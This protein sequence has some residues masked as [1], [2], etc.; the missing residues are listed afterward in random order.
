MH[1]ILWRRL[2]GAGHDACR[3]QRE[4]DGWSLE[5][6]AV[7]EAEG[8]AAALSYRLDCG[9][10]W[11]SRSARVAGWIGARRFDLRLDRQ[12]D[13]RWRI[14]GCPD[15]ALD[16]LLDID[17]GFTPATN[18]NA[19]RRMGLAVGSAAETVAVW[20]DTEDWKVKRLPQSYSRS[21]DR[22]YLYASPQHG[23]RAT[24]L[25]DGFGAVVRYP[26]LWDA[27]A[28]A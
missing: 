10:D 22:N 9:P 21:G 12:A 8:V 3:W 5:G 24:L 18:T 6:M 2:D 4:G 23:Y 7:F 26:G 27:C 25:V 20:L 11:A 13:G 17:L 16:G 14:D 28:P 19:I 1:T 15:A